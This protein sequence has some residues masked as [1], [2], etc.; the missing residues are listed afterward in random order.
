MAGMI[1]QL[2]TG[3]FE[4]AAKV[5]VFEQD[6]AIEAKRVHRPSEPVAPL[7]RCAEHLVWASAAAATN[8]LPKFVHDIEAALKH[9]DTK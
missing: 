7:Q 1:D 9:A 3:F 2:V 8:T 6:A 5:A 4:V